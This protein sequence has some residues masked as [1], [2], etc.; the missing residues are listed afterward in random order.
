MV[1]TVDTF[2]CTTPSKFVL[3]TTPALRRVGSLCVYPAL[4]ITRATG[5]LVNTPTNPDGGG[6]Y[7]GARGG[8]DLFGEEIR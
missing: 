2:C 5:T 6:V 3:V 8:R 4:F 7:G 1:M